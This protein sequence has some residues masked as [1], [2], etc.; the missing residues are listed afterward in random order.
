M[1][2]LKRAVSEC[3]YVQ[4][5]QNR[6]ISMGILLLASKALHPSLL[7]RSSFWECVR[8]CLLGSKRFEEFC[9]HSLRDSK[10]L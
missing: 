10:S 2:D 1:S 9:V 3:E 8:V 4:T 7:G 5:V 6:D